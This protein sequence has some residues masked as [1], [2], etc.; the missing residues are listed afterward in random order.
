MKIKNL[1]LTGVETSVCV[2]TTLRAAFTKGYNVIVPVDLVAMEKE[3]WYQH[4][5][6]LAI[7]DAVFAHLTSFAEITGAFKSWREKNKL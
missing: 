7:W 3:R 1:V 4:E 5:A 6:T 2:D